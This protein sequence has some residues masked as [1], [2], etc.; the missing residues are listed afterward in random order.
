MKKKI[1]LLLFC[2]LVA[3]FLSVGVSICYENDNAV[4]SVG[5]DKFILEVVSDENKTLDAY[6]MGLSPSVNISGE[7]AYAGLGY[8]ENF[9]KS[10]FTGKIALIKRGMLKFDDKVKN[11]YDAGAIGVLIYNNNPGIFLGILLSESEIPAFII[12]QADGT[13]L[14]DLMNRT[15]VVVRCNKT[16]TKIGHVDDDLSDYPAANF[17]SVQDAIDATPSPTQHERITV[18]TYNILNGAGVDALYPGNKEWVARHGY[19]GNRLPMVLEVIKAADPDILGIQEAHQWDIGSPSVAQEVADQLGMNYFIGESTNPECGFANVVLFTKFDIKEAESYSSHFTRAGLRAEL[20]MPN[21]QLISVFV[22]HLDATSYEIRMS[23]LSFLVGEMQPYIDKFTILMGDMNFLDLQAR[24]YQFGDDIQ[25]SI[26]YEAGW[27]HPLGSS[28]EID[29]IWTSSV[30]E[31]YVQPA[32]EIPSELTSGTSDHRPVVVQIRI[33]ARIYYVD[34]DGGADFTGIQDAVI[35]AS[36]GDMIIVRDG[37]YI[38]N[39]KVDKSLKIQS[40][41]G[42]ASTIVQAQNLKDNVFTVTANYVTISGFTVEGA[43]K[44]H[45]AGIYLY[46]VDYCNIMNNNCSSNDCPGIH[47]RNSNN[48]CIANNTCSNNRA[49]IRLR[50]NSNS[51]FIYVN[52]FINNADNVYFYDLA[53]IWN[54]TELITYTY[55]GSKY[56]NYLGNYWSDYTGSDSD[57]DGIGDTP[58]NINLDTDDYPLMQPFENY[59]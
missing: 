20:V 44:S 12:S 41:N 54:S 35:A 46:N 57:G 52:N 4:G 45:N 39:I 28:Q 1:F 37:T 36:A 21:G 13:Y 26:L 6:L 25:A 15:T 40:E 34:D 55:N 17:S 23:E 33:P 22:V 10:S 18:M 58:Y 27:C 59:I 53:N 43:T 5:T 51:N 11:A 19:P 56:T 31:P 30:L 2:V 8:P 47:L 29:Q 49:G 24:H 7:L 48:N 32:P 3:F 9:S 14:L 42:P 38:E 16:M 50:W